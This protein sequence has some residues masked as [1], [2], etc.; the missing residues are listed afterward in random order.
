MGTTRWSASC[1]T[2]TRPTNR[3]RKF[4]WRRSATTIGGLRVTVDPIRARF[5]TWYE[6][7]PRSCGTFKDCERIIPEVAEMGFD[8]LYFPPIHPIGRTHR[9]GKN[10]SREA[11]PG[12]PGSPWAIGSK[13]GGHKAVH[14]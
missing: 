2:G 12:E 1:D 8:V 11:E 9:K 10:N 4:P 6:M 14:R 5:S 13:K 3:G 7:F